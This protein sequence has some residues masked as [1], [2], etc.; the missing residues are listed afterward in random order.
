MFLAY[1]RKSHSFMVVFPGQMLTL[2]TAS[3]IMIFETLSAATLHNF[4]V[5][6]P[7]LSSSDSV[8]SIW[9]LCATAGS[10]MLP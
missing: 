3:G 7:D 5:F 9:P 2:K 8:Y 10:L 6:V 1:L 4:A